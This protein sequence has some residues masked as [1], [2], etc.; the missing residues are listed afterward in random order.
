MS[1]FISHSKA[2]LV[3]CLISNST[4]WGSHYPRTRIGI[5][6][7]WV[8]YW[9]LNHASL[10]WNFILS[11]TSGLEGI[12][13][14]SHSRIFFSFDIVWFF[15]DY[16][17]LYFIALLSWK[18][19]YPPTVGYFPVWTHILFHYQSHS[20]ELVWNSFMYSCLLYWLWSSIGSKGRFSQRTNTI[21]CWYKYILSITCGTYNILSAYKIPIRKFKENS[22]GGIN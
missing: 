22:I 6:D 15:T 1:F 17:S 19:F 13:S 20:C 12:L 2:D 21:S 14:S 9:A 8:S 4:S 10:L 18:E 7:M 3:P 11:S 5:F 16:V